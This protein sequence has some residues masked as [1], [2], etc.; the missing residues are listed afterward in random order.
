MSETILFSLKFSIIGVF[1]VFISLALIVLA[2]SLIK[3]ANDYWIKHEDLQRK[4]MLC[5]TQNI[6]NITLAIIAAAVS[7]MLLGRYHIKGVRRYLPG[8][9]KTSPWS[10]E[11]RAILHGSHIISKK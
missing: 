8:D 11:G 6:D 9:L 7:T 2:I 4:Q 5:K 3:G 1:I 10:S